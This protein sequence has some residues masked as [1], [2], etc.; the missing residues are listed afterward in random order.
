MQD[1]LRGG[2]RVVVES[3]RL[4]S[5][6]M[7]SP[8]ISFLNKSWIEA[9]VLTLVFVETRTGGVQTTSDQRSVAMPTC[10]VGMGTERTGDELENIVTNMASGKKNR[11]SGQRNHLV[12]AI[13]SAG[14]H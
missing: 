2:S 4:G 5:N 13:E 1:G 6:S 12:R 14:P 3:S 11:L 9:T 10:L 8:G 7:R